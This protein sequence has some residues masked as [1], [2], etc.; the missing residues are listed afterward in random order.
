MNVFRSKQ[1][2]LAEFHAQYPVQLAA[3]L[4]QFIQAAREDMVA[5][6]TRG[7]EDIGSM[8]SVSLRDHDGHKGWFF[9]AFRQLQYHSP[10]EADAPSTSAWYG[11]T[12]V[13]LT[14]QYADYGGGCRPDI[15]IL[16]GFDCNEELVNLWFSLEAAEPVAAALGIVHDIVV[17]ACQ[18]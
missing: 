18:P 11:F 3:W 7:M 6:Q 17:D 12:P 9:V 1:L 15:C 13:M 14:A 16:E 4:A 5:C 8:S 2:T 10:F